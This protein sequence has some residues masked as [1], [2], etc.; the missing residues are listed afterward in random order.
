MTASSTTILVPSH[1]VGS[2]LASASKISCASFPTPLP[3][4]RSAS[5]RC[6]TAAST[7]EAS[8]FVEMGVMGGWA[9]LNGADEDADEGR[10]RS[11]K[12]WM[13]EIGSTWY[14][15]A[16]V[17]ERAMR[18]VRGQAV[19][20]VP[21]RVETVGLLVV[22]R[23]LPGRQETLA[24]MF[25]QSTRSHASCSLK[26]QAQYIIYNASCVRR[27]ANRSHWQSSP[28]TNHSAQRA[29][30]RHHTRR[31]DIG[32]SRWHLPS[33]IRTLGLR[34][35]GAATT[36]WCSGEGSFQRLQERIDTG[37]WLR[38]ARKPHSEDAAKE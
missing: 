33:R 21:S 3:L 36:L 19:K 20:S 25:H 1:L 18:F 22:T 28:C 34:H 13:V 32:G 16:G 11:A 15:E 2:V 6:S 5:F 31:P 23:M 12:F 8:A 17:V 38:N 7:R 35:A 14:V 37:K 29:L 10:E 24:V 30:Q 4:R 26:Q 27:D 9:L